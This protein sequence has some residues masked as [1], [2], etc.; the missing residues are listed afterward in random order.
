MIDRGVPRLVAGFGRSGTTWVQDVM[1]TANRMRAVFEP[2]QP[3][4]IRGARPHAHRYLAAGDDDPALYRFLYPY[5]CGRYHSLWADYRLIFKQFYPRP[6]DFRSP[7]SIYGKLR[8]YI[9]AKDYYLR[10]RGQRRYEGRIIK[11]VRANMMLG[12]LQENFQA[13]IVF[14]VR[15]PAA[16]ILSQMSAP[17]AWDPVRR[18]GRYRDDRR[19]LD[20][21]D[22]RFRR[23]LY[24]PL[25]LVE[26]HTLSWCIENTIALRQ[27]AERG[28]AIVFYEH[29]VV[30]G[31]V[32]WPRI[33]AALALDNA[34]DEELVTRPSQQT[35]G[36]RLAD[37]TL[38][39]RYASWKERIDQNTADRIQAV[40][41]AVGVTIYNM[42]AALPT[43][44]A[45]D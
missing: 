35:W 24:Q 4:A 3:Y 19:L 31:D 2:L 25:D 39:R 5:F 18:L 33:T 44:E 21:L 28:I 30:N 38:L 16:V 29:L 13:R 10:Y 32:E 37:P 9:Q 42:G 17:R 43:S 12:W 41:N 36:E 40:L 45:D 8:Y 20:Q 7:S 15:H 27:A 34:P 14:L 1:A 6:G 23:L 22:N 11:C 26:A